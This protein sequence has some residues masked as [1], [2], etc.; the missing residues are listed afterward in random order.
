[1]AAGMHLV[2]RGREERLRGHVMLLYW[3]SGRFV[4]L[5]NVAEWAHEDPD[6]AGEE[7]FEAADD[8]G[9]GL[10]FGHPNRA[11]QSDTTVVDQRP[12]RHEPTHD[13]TK[14]RQRKPGPAFT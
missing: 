1:M 6:F 4:G 9:F 2:L 8:F 13:Q 11:Y 7:A 5:W 10:A 12:A 14:A 3:S